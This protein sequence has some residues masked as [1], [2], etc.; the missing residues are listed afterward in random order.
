MS[1]CARLFAL[2]ALQLACQAPALIS[3]RPLQ[4]ARSLDISNA[5][6]VHTVVPSE[7]NEHQDWQ[8]LGLFWSWKKI[9]SPGMFTRI[10]CCE[11]DKLKGQQSVNPYQVYYTN[12]NV[13]PE[14]IED[15]YV[16]YNK[17]YGV[18]SWLQDVDPAGD[19]FLI[20][21]PDMTF[22]RSFT[23]DEL[24][25]GPGWGASQHMWYMKE[26]N[27]FIAHKLLPSKS[28][29]VGSIK[30]QLTTKRAEA[31][32]QHA[33]KGNRPAMATAQPD[34]TS[35]SG[36]HDRHGQ[37]T[38]LQ[39]AAATLLNAEH[40]SSSGLPKAVLTENAATAEQPDESVH[41]RALLQVM[42]SSVLT[43]Q[44]AA[45]DADSAAVEGNLVSQFTALLQQQ[46]PAEQLANASSKEQAVKILGHGPPQRSS[47]SLLQ[48]E[49]AVN[50]L[51]EEEARLPLADEVGEL[52]LYAAEDLRHIAP[53]WWN[54]TKQMRVFHETYAKELPKD[55]PLE[56]PWIAEM[57]GI[58]LGAAQLGVHHHGYNDLVMH[59]P[60]AQSA[61]NKEGPNLVV[62]H[63]AWNAEVPSLSWK[64]NKHAFKNWSVLS[65][66]PWNLDQQFSREA[67]G[68][69]YNG[70]TGGLFPHP[71]YP[72]ELTNQAPADIFQ[73]LANIE[74]V[75]MLNEGFCELHHKMYCPA[76]EELL[77]ECG[78][79][80]RVM[81]ELVQYY[82]RLANG[83]S[84]FCLDTV[85]HHCA[86]VQQAPNKE[87]LC[88]QAAVR[89]DCHRTCDLCH[90]GFD[91]SSLVWYNQPQG[92]AAAAQAWHASRAADIGHGAELSSQ[93]GDGLDS[94][95]RDLELEEVDS[96]ARA[97]HAGG[98]SSV[99]KPTMQQG[100]VN[101]SA[102]EPE[103][104]AGSSGKLNGTSATISNATEAA[105]SLAD[106]A[107]ASEE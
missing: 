17:P 85:P 87:E 4:G 30:R 80:T 88:Q 47:R 98:H 37:T 83:S 69:Q 26:L 49:E 73:D 55:T 5:Q 71:P 59:P 28:E 31:G 12:T 13:D 10:A 16:P 23:V 104:V 18:M 9:G 53:L 44:Y 21:D 51:G 101:S 3:T 66:P 57:Y 77:R 39:A 1:S 79:A 22:H 8:V 48:E 58:A 95:L 92:T 2:V 82:Q 89:D 61:L 67:W 63:Y 97:G 56:R 19:Y 35:A 91:S 25:A 46:K 62:S 24:K 34:L 103:R 27:Q 99:D 52:Y 76:S 72:S 68:E 38:L 70:S 43:A 20:V 14:G 50:M 40:A 107:E 78:K 32:H 41:Q 100:H 105:G 15:N 81:Q 42:P 106:E 60:G 74:M 36:Q 86:E 64:W 93:E 75:G 102:V 29:G 7:C 90:A 45:T 11:M 84:I 6:L 54:Y 65:C 96:A 94:H 33:N